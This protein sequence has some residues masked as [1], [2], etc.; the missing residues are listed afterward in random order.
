MEILFDHGGDPVGG[1]VTNCESMRNSHDMA[2]SCHVM[3]CVHMDDVVYVC[4]CD[5][6]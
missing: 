3:S 2:M 4:S 6:C 5:N 1:R